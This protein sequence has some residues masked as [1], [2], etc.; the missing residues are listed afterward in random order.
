M[1]LVMTLLVRD[2]ADIVD[3]QIAYHLDAGVDFVVATDNRSEDGTTEILERYE[4]D[5]VL[6]LIR[7]PGD[8]LRQSEWV[9]RKARLAAREFGA[10]WILNTDADEFW[11]ARGGSFE[12]LFAAVPE[13]FGAVRGAWRNFVPRPD[14][15]RFFAERMTARLCTPSF[16]PHPLSTHFKSAHRAWPGV[17]IGRGNHEALGDG[18]VALRG[19]Y[20]IE[21]LHFPVR[22][23][24]QCRRKYVTQ[25]VALERNAEKGIPGHMAEAYEAYRAGTLDSY[26]APLVVADEAL[27]AGIAGGTY[28]VDTRLRDRLRSLGF[29]GAERAGDGVESPVAPSVA[30]AAV[31]AGEYSALG[32]SDLGL[33]F[34]ERVDELEARLARLERSPAARVR[35][36]AGSL[37]S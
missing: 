1:K 30:D 26:Y 19:W 9:T 34:G 10:D 33:S 36:L 3:A 21:I 16:H 12:E 24:E 37:R 2:E 5:G 15:G 32:E 20:P 13:R 28:A 25:F 7:E 18:L 4:R 14:D 29:G 27:E 6:H 22:S 23:L 11:H 31:F 17:R 8:D 35:R